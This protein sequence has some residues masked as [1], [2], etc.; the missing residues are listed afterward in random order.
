MA[1]SRPKGLLEAPGEP[2]P[3]PVYRPGCLL[4]QGRLANDRASKDRKLPFRYV[5][6]DIRTLPEKHHP[7]PA[8]AGEREETVR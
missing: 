2:E 4:G 8:V 7:E 5:I 3:M 6:G 1:P